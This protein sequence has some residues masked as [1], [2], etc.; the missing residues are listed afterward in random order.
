MSTAGSPEPRRRRFTPLGRGVAALALSL[1]L[2]AALLVGLASIGFGRTGPERPLDVLGLAPLTASDWDAN[3][4]IEGQPRD[5]TPPVPT[6]P[7]PP[8]VEPPVPD[9]R[10]SQVAEVSP[11]AEGAGQKPE[12]GEAT[13][14]AN[15]DS[16]AEK[17]RVSRHADVRNENDLPTPQSGR[18]AAGAKRAAG[19]GGLDEAS[20]PERD[21]Q[22]GQRGTGADRLS[23]PSQGGEERVA[24]AADGELG[25]QPRPAQEKMAGTGERPDLPGAPGDPARA[26]RSAGSPDDRLR[27]SQEVL[28]RIAG[29]PMMSFEGMEEGES[30][31]LNARE[32]KYATYFNRVYRGIGGQW[33]PERAYQLRDPGLS[34]YPVQDR[35]T[36]LHLKL[37]ATGAVK[38]LRL[39][40]G[41]GLGF[42]DQ[43]AMRAIRAA[44]PFPNPPSAIVHDGEIDYGQIV[45]TFS[46]DRSGRFFPRR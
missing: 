9:V 33:D 7:P 19:D 20:T 27:P 38:E 43:E 17:N 5:G 22:G 25:L 3:R 32:F 30:T 37:D 42:L 46:F 39:V 29:G 12:P 44:A 35:R 26:L 11:E 36:V 15:R 24:M 18:V 10:G 8:P 31:V 2:H 34:I 21:G 13:L 28:E 6:P 23:V 41:S 45:F 1:A 40:K 16:F 14:W 4:A